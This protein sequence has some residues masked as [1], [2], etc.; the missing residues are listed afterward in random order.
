MSPTVWGVKHIWWAGHLKTREDFERQRGRFAR[1][2]LDFTRH[3]LEH[4]G[5]GARELRSKTSWRLNAVNS[6]PL[7]NKLG[8]IEDVVIGGGGGVQKLRSSKAVKNN[9]PLTE[10]A[11]VDCSR[12]RPA[13]DW[14]RWIPA[15]GSNGKW[16]T[17][18]GLTC[19]GLGRLRFDNGRTVTEMVL[20]KLD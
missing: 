1:A 7:V 16:M 11:A 17:A 2:E 20:K 14:A 9:T 15:I 8:R 12:V 10:R 19:W 3:D 18:N 4:G 13:M 5:G 6:A